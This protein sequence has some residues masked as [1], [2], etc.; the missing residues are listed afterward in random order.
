MKRVLKFPLKFGAINALEIPPNGKVTLVGHQA[1]EEM[2]WAECDDAMP[3]VSTRDFVIFGT[4]RVIPDSSQEPLASFQHVG[5]YQTPAGFVWH[6]YEVTG[7]PQ[8][9]FL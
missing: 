4:G 9:L 3:I 6:I 5:S 1:G 2:L 8:S 7:K